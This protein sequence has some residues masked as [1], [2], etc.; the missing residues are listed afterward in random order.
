MNSTKTASRRPNPEEASWNLVSISPSFIVKDLQVSIA[1]YIERFGFQLDFQGP[2]GDV[3]YGRVRRD[4]IGIFLKTIVPDVLPCPNHTRHEWARW[5]A[6]IVTL[7]PDALFDEFRQ[8]GVSFVKELSFIDD[9]L[10]GFEVSDA[11]GYV[12][13]FFRVRKE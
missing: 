8:R 9:G 13:A 5:D 1:Y 11:D 3:F 2:D 10:W 6:Y 12:L 4:G 7:D